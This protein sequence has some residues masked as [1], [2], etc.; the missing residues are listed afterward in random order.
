MGMFFFLFF[1]SC[2]S[3]SKPVPSDAVATVEVAKH[4]IEVGDYERVIR[5]LGPFVRRYSQVPDL[6]F[7]MALGYLGQ[8][9]VDQAIGFFQR[10]LKLDP[11]ADDARL[12]L[13]Y[14]L[15]AKGD[16][17][18]AQWHLDELVR[19]NRYPYLGKV[20]LNYG[21]IFLKKGDFP[22]AISYFEESLVHDPLS[23][24][25][26]YNLGLCH[27]HQAQTQ[28]AEKFLSRAV[29]ACGHCFDPSFLHAKVLKNLGKKE[30]A[31][32]ILSELSKNN[33]LSERQKKLLDQEQ[34]SE[35]P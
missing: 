26:L 18:Q 15:I 10:V 34:R 33:R 4:H 20:Y 28:E 5:D 29:Q 8:G 17:S 25:T 32:A 12:N 1:F 27:L 11:K 30:E 13:S 16:F 19:K 24:S 9:N 7:L 21:L 23:S 6:N 35:K 3:T 2:Q 22:Q 31:Q 14:A